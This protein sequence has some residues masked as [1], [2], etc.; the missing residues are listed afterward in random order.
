VVT[1]DH[2]CGGLTLGWA[3]TKYASNFELLGSQNVSFQKFTDE[4]LKQYMAENATGAFDSIK[5]LITAHFGL[6][7]AGDTTTDYMVLKPHEI[8][9]LESAYKLSMAGQKELSKDPATALMYGGYDPLAVALTHT[10]NNKAG[11]GWT[12]FKHT[13]VPVSTSAYGV[14]AKTF[15]GYYDNTDIAK[16][17]M[18]IMGVIPKVHYLAD[19]MK[20]KIA[21]R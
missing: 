18:A 9:Q 12:S 16:K 19:D 20:E 21:A 1:G 7:F 15:N 5:P 2:E 4:I 3:G 6:K 8:A 14:G 11:L 10:V 17:I 13:G